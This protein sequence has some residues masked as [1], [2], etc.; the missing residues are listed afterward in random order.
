ML[1]HFIILEFCKV[2]GVKINIKGRFNGRP[3]A[4]SR[5]II[6]GDVAVQSFNKKVEYLQKTVYTKN[7]TFGIEIWVSCLKIN[8]FTT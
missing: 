6:V 1:N 8:D 2:K 3:R 7:G 5:S 4:R